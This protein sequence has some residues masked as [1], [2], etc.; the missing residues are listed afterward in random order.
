MK[1]FYDLEFLE[2]GP[3]LPI[4]L[5]SLGMVREDGETLY[6]INAEMP[7]SAVVRHPWLQIN[8]VPYLPLSFPNPGIVAWDEAHPDYAFV[9]ARDEIAR[10]VLEFCTELGK[11]E[12]WAYYGAFKHVVLAQLFGATTDYPPGLPQYTNDV[13]QLWAGLGAPDSVLPGPGDEPN[14]H[15]GAMFVRDA[16]RAVDDWARSEE[17][18]NDMFAALTD[19][20]AKD[21]VVITPCEH[22]AADTP[23]VL[24]SCTCVRNGPERMALDEAFE[25]HARDIEA[26][27]RATEEDK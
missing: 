4:S 5:I 23:D 16:W 19:T 21:I 24:K 6:L 3:D 14:T 20:P 1:I 18:L 15:Q 26:A 7:L 25:A 8:V 22:Y 11:P 10:Q 13:V 12:L 9:K 17:R 2:R 27:Y